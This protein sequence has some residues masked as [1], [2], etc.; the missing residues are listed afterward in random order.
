MMPY[1]PAKDEIETLWEQ[2][3]ALHSQLGERLQ[4]KEASMED[5]EHA[6]SLGHMTSIHLK[7]LLDARRESNGKLLNKMRDA[8]NFQKAS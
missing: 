4:S 5:I 6:F 2:L 7:I 8:R 1:K 3:W